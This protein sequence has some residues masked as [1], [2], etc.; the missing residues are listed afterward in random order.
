MPGEAGLLHRVARLVEALD[1]RV[2]PDGE[3]VGEF[4]QRRLGARDRIL[5]RRAHV[6]GAGFLPPPS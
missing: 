6:G 4:G 1:F 2:H 3:I 5:V